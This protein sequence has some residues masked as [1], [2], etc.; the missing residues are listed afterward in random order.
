M[1]IVRLAAIFHDVGHMYFSHA[2]ERYFTENTNYSRFSDIKKMID[3]FSKAIDDN[4]SLRE[5]IGIM[6][7]NS[8]SVQELLLKIAPALS[9]E[10]TTKCIM[11]ITE[12]ISCLMLGQ[13]NNMDLLPY[14]QIINGSL[15]ADKCD[16]LA[17]DSHATNVPVAV[18]IYRL[19]HK[20][21]V[22]EDKYPEELDKIGVDAVRDFT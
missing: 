14:H 3:D 21:S 4:I 6:I 12:S 22:N 2:S 17:R 13:A 11:E 19:I 5:L 10:Q 15:D 7:V 1:Q 8:P 16:Y 9:L 18:D 20:L